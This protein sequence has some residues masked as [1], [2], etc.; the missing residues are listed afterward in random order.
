MCF[1]GPH[2]FLLTVLDECPHVVGQ[3]LKCGEER[4][5]NPFGKQVRPR[6]DKVGGDPKGRTGFM[7]VLDKDARLVNMQVLAQRL[8]VLLH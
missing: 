7:S 8:Y 4:V 3:C 5:I 1:Y 2:T 6:C